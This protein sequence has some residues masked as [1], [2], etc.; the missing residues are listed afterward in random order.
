MTPNT[1]SCSPKARETPDSARAWGPVVWDVVVRRAVDRRD[2]AGAA[3]IEAIGT[4]AALEALSM[5]A[6]SVEVPLASID[7]ETAPLGASPG[8]EAQTVQ[9]KSA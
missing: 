1:R 3:A 6:L 4:A 2:G 9:T 7:R 8:D 5:E